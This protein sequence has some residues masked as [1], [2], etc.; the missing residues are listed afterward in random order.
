MISHAVHIK[1]IFSVNGET[2]SSTARRQNNTIPI[3]HRSLGPYK[4]NTKRVV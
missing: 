2:A 3:F 1:P 4:Y